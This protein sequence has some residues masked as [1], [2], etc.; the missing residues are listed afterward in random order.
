MPGPQFRRSTPSL[1]ESAGRRAAS[2]RGSAPMPRAG[3]QLLPVASMRITK[4][5]S[6]DDVRS[7]VSKKM[8]PRKGRKN[9]SMMSALKPSAYTRRPGR[10]GQGGTAMSAFVLHRTAQRHRAGRPASP[11]PRFLAWRLTLQNDPVVHT[12]R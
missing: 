12:S 5:V 7:W 2:C 1:T 6:R 3:R 10:I 8:P 11:I 4:D 9:R